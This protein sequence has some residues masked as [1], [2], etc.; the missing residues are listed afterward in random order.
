MMFRSIGTR[1]AF[2]A[3]S[4]QHE[5]NL[6]KFNTDDNRFL[7]HRILKKH[8]K[9]NFTGDIHLSTVA[10]VSIVAIVKV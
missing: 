3:R 2:K 7:A 5:M 10:F 8:G 9:D 6:G 1:N 4:N